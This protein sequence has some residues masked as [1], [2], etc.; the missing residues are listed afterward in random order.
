MNTP[1]AQIPC[2]TNVADPIH[3][4][5]LT[6]IPLSCYLTVN[7]RVMLTKN[8]GSLTPLG[9]NNGAL[10][11]II[12]IIYPPDQRPP[13]PPTAVIV[14]FP[15]YKGP[16]FFHGHNTWVPI[17]QDIVRC[18]SN[19]CFRKNI[20]LISG[21]A[22]TIAKSQGMTIGPSSDIQ[23]VIIKMSE[24]PA[25][26]N[27]NLGQAYTAFSRASNDM[28]WCIQDTFPFSRLQAINK[29]KG[30]KQ[31]IEEEDRLRELEK[32]T[33][34]NY[35]ISTK[36]YINLILEIDSYCNDGIHD[37]VCLN[38]TGQCTCCLHC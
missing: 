20:P 16:P 36:E 1:F 31:R 13:S 27:R 12:S 24:S 37:A 17:V 25:M 23:R 35:T 11:N 7:S 5:D 30:M 33:K 32:E 14:D 6:Q 10:G 18:G 19:C 28:A 26:E 21:Y 3:K 34:R 4:E 38:N 2:E 8:Q 9:L 29:H 22:L 15:G